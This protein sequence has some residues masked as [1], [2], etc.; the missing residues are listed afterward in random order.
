MSSKLF[1]KKL[2]QFWFARRKLREEEE[3]ELL[4]V[5]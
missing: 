3:E 5:A 4:T 2:L 1:L